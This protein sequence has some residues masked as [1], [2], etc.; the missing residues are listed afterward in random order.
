[1][2]DKVIQSLNEIIEKLS[3]MESCI[4]LGEYDLIAGRRGD[5][6]SG[7]LPGRLFPNF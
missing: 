1:M 4:G 3:K 6:L 2:L 5:L 7:G